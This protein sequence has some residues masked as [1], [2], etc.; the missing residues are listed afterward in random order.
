MKEHLKIEEDTQRL[1]SGHTAH[2]PGVLRSET[3][4]TLETR[5]AQ[6]LITGRRA[7]PT[8][9]EIIGLTK[10]SSLLRPIWS[11]ARSDDPYADW[12]LIKIEEILDGAKRELERIE[13][14]IQQRLHDVPAINVSVAHSV[15]PIR[16]PLQFSNPY[17]FR[18]AYLIADCDRVIR[19]ILTARH[20]GLIGRDESEKLI[21]EAG[22]A[23]RR[24]LSS[25]V[26]YRFK[27]INRDD[28]QQQTARGM[29]ARSEMGELPEEVLEG[30]RRASY[31]PSP[32]MKAG[33]G[34]GRIRLRNRPEEEGTTR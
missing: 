7:E 33:F 28:L 12:W 25:P 3:W 27:G 9:P 15:E 19:A 11:G 8:K 10:F 13:H 29:E 21:Y 6:R 14:G 34:R 32:V 17:A 26:G 24:A 23:V 22:R 30:K 4:L 18:G 5:Q 31:G 16:V 1:E 2:Q 20:V